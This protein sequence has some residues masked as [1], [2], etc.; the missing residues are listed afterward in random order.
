MVFPDEE[1]YGRRK[2]VERP[3][4]VLQD[5]DYNDNP[6]FKT[7]AIAPISTQG[8]YKTILDI[9]LKR[10]NDGV[11]QDCYVRLY[12]MQPI[13]KTNLV[14][15][16]NKISADKIDELKATLIFFLGLS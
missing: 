15:H 6:L 3:V 9:E 4:V 2:H 16:V 12:L 1:L 10:S 7:I 13:L 5:N 14:K 8:Q 11:R